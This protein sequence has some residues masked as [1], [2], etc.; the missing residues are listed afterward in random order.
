MRTGNGLQWESL[1]RWSAT[2]FI[3]SGVFW[4]ADTLLLGLELVDIYAHGLLNGVFILAALLTTM[5]GL[6]GFYPRL[7]DRVPRLALASAMVG[8]VAAGG[9]VVGF[10]WVLGTI[11]LAGVSSPPS[12][13]L[14]VALVA[15]GLFG[16]VS[17]WSDRPSRTVGFLLLAYLG[18]LVGAFL[19]SNGLQFG[20]AG[21]VSV[22]AVAIAY[23][24]HTGGAGLDQAESTA[25]AT[26]R[27]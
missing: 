18:F 16:V 5:L 13:F 8:A 20:L 2:A 19:A 26:A 9:L 10:V 21:L 14:L 27:R 4:L 1:G 6:L 25:D 23:V 15:L 7:A 12:V 24:H 22:N 17:L 3:I 11:A